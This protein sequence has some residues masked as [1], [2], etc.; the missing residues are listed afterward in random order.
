ME[1]SSILNT[2]KLNEYES[3]FDDAGLDDVE[4]WPD[5]TLTELTNIIKSMKPAHAEKFVRK[6]KQMKAHIIHIQAEAEAIVKAD[7]FDAAVDDDDEFVREDGIAI[8]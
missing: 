6:A 5:I 1:V 8:G 7:V 4:D 3:L 2:W